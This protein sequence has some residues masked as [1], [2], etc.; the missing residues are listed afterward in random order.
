MPK[1]HNPN[2]L[3]KGPEKMLKAKDLNDPT[4]I[5]DPEAGMNRK[6]K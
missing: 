3:P 2:H 5:A 1:T 6:E 4:I